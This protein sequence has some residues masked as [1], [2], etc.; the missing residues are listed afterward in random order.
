MILLR[1]KDIDFE[2]TYI[3][4]QEKPDWFLEIS[5]HGKVPV[6]SV[7][8]VPLF[9]SNAIAE[10]LDEMVEPKLHPADPIKRARN[11]A[12]TDFVPD[13]AKGLS[14]IY[15]TKDASA[16]EEGLK[17]APTRLAKLEEALATERGNDGPYFNGETLCLVDAAYAPFL[18]R[19]AFVE[20]KLQTGVLKDFPL[21]QAW[22]DALLASD[23]VTG[24]VVSHFED[25][26]VA[27]LKRRGFYVGT[28]FEGA[29]AAAE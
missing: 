19:F 3:N 12:W 2:V 7:D 27:S 18:Q 9:E 21:V 6:L 29:S 24:S 10:Y 15:Y 5:P 26:F 13:F 20:E 25:E 4:L 1:A 8:G 14:G 28:L 17:V 16:M 22:S 23:T 11:R